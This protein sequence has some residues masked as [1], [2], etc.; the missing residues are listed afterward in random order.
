MRADVAHVGVTGLSASL[1]PNGRIVAICP[2]N[3]VRRRRPPRRAPA[4]G[5]GSVRENDTC[6]ERRHH[7]INHSLHVESHRFSGSLADQRDR[8]PH[9]VEQRTGLLRAVPAAQNVPYHRTAGRR[10]HFLLI[11]LR[12]GRQIL[13]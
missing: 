2:R 1:S 13:R 11:H 5:Q 4:W 3:A 7:G 8:G 9:R 10:V 12:P 6:H